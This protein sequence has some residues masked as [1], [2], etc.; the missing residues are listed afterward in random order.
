MAKRET[1]QHHFVD[2]RQQYDAASLGMWLFLITEIL[3]FGGLFLGYAVYRL[4]YPQAF[5]AG[6]SHLNLWLGGI[7]TVVLITSS[8]TMVL[9][10]HAA[11][12][13][14]QKQLIIFLALTLALGLAFM[15]VK[16]VEYSS[17][18]HEHLIPGRHFAFHGF[19]GPGIELFFSFYFSMTGLHALH[20]IIGAGLLT[21]LIIRSCQ[22]RFDAAYNTPVDMVGLYWHLVDIVWIY[23]FPLLYLIGRT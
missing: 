7:N 16:A 19:S 4:Q 12:H 2:A 22:G 8:L 6:S 15:G 3:F 18:F 21:N 9:A 1:L 11:Q 5:L 13:S 14:R 17:K 10:V 23:L 20:M